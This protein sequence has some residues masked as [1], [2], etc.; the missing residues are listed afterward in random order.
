MSATLQQPPGARQNR[1]PAFLVVTLIF[2]IVASIVVTLRVYIR[3]W[4][5]R[6]F[7]WDDGVII[8]SL[9]SARLRIATFA[10]DSS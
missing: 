5:K 8:F 3:V 6:T 1:G 2:T 4:V 10:S 7:G 9:V